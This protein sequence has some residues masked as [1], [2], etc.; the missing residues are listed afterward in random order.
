MI[1]LSESSRRKTEGWQGAGTAVS[2]VHTSF[3]MFSHG[4]SRLWAESALLVQAI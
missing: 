3:V 2:R 4:V 1:P